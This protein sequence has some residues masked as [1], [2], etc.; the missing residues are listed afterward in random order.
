MPATPTVPT[1]RYRRESSLVTMPSPASTV[2]NPGDLIW[3]NAGVAATA[4]AF[5][6]GASLG[7]TQSGFRLLFLGVAQDMKIA[8]DTST[9]PIGIRTE[10][11]FEF[12]CAALASAAH[13]GT[14]VGPAQDAAGNFLAS[15]VLAPV[16][17]FANSI[18]TVVE[19]AAVGQTFLVVYLQSWLL[20]TSQGVAS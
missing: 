1:Y 6:W 18:G 7:A 20:Y 11:V 5:T 13:I 10:G 3:Q 8:S 16:A 2:I 12:P 19:E 14:L 15:Q 17:A 4:G 9:T